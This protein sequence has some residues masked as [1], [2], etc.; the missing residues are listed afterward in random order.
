[1][2]YN[3]LIFVAIISKRKY[4]YVSIMGKHLLYLA[5][6]G[7]DMKLLKITFHSIVLF[8]VELVAQQLAPEL[9]VNNIEDT[10]PPIDT[11]NERYLGLQ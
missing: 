9:N 5:I 3:G 7:I 8:F 2:K 6:M 1:M 4:F 10:R 11:T